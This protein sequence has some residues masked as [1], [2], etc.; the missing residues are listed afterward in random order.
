MVRHTPSQ[1]VNGNVPFYFL[2]GKSKACTTRG[3]TL[4]EVF[5]KDK[6]TLRN[7]N[8]SCKRKTG[9]IVESGQ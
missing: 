7:S 3:S 5:I 2:G 1:L 8:L 4:I 9:H 6:A